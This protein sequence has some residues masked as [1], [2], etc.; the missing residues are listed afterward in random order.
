MDGDFDVIDIVWRDGLF[1]LV[2]ARIEQFHSATCI[3]QSYSRPAAV[4]CRLGIVR[5]VASEDECAGGL[6]QT[7]TDGGRSIAIHAMF[8]GIFYK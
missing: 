6:F 7:Y 4:L 1:P 8:E 2:A 3:F 5:I